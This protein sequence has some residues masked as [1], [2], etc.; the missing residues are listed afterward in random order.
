MGKVGW[1]VAFVY[2]AAAAM[3][4]AR[5]NTQVGVADKRFFQGLPSPTAAAILA[6]L[7]WVFEDY[8]LMATDVSW[9]IAALVLLVGMLM[10]SNVRYHSFKDLDLHGRVPFVMALV[11]VSVLVLITVQPPM[12]LF[13]VFLGYAL[14]GPIYTLSV[15]RELR[16]QKS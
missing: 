13:L 8:G 2:T 15:L 16:K 10:V 4:L 9:L 6:G 14:S 12:I 7:V 5:F 3:R 1:L 11:V